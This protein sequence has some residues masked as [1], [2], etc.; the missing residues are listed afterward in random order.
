MNGVHRHDGFF[1]RLTLGPGAGAIG[2]D[3]KGSV[4]DTAFAGVGWAS[5][6]DIGGS[7]GD[8]LAIFGRLR[9]ASL[10]NPTVYV[11][12]D[13]VADA[14]ASVVSQSMIGGGVSYFLMPLNMYLGAAV[15][16]AVV[17][18]QY[19]RPNRATREFNSKVG[20]GLDAEIGKEWW[21]ADDWGLGLAARFSFADAAA[22][23][24]LPDDAR[25]GAAFVSVLLSATYQ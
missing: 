18:G 2:I 23:D 22:G 16:L 21:I 17:S 9:H 7:N 14:D 12:D 15:G 3:A 10:A 1:L 24:A 5:S 11:N 13:E 19:K 8:N 25:F 4:D 6:L 20:F